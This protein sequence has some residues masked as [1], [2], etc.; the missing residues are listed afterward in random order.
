MVTRWSYLDDFFVGLVVD[1]QGRYRLFDVAKDDVEM[2][3]VRL[4]YQDVSL[5]YEMCYE[6]HEA[7]LA[8]LGRLE[9]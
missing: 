5:G 6:T 3:V 9:A 1:L 4:R 7:S 2:L 8:A